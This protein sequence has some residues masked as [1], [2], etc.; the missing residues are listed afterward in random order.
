MLRKTNPLVP[1][2]MNLRARMWFHL[3][4]RG[5]VKPAPFYQI[6]GTDAR[7]AKAHLEAQFQP[8]MS[9]ENYGQWH[10]DHI[11]PLASAKTPE[12]LVALC[13]YTNLQPLWAADN[14]RK[15]AKIERRP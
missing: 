2:R 14:I 9:W 1:L 7:G 10:V 5:S 6:L 11:T 4:R 3:V 13:H 8:G 15:G 12:E